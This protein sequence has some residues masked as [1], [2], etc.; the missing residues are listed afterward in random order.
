[1][2]WREKPCSARELMQRLSIRHRPSFLYRY[3]R[4]ALE[5]GLVEMTRPEAPRSRNQRYRLTA[6]GR[7]LR[8][9]RVARDA[10]GV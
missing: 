10:D 1:M 3:L 5:P 8:G 6:S 7:R 9:R 2:S 4:P